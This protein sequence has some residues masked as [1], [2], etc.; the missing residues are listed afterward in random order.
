MILN[1]VHKESNLEVL[2]SLYIKGGDTSSQL[3]ANRPC[4]RFYA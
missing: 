1:E 2:D 4:P 3:W